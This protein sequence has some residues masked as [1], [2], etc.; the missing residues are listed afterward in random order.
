AAHRDPRLKASILFNGDLFGTARY[1]THP[2]STSSPDQLGAG[3]QTTQTGY[4]LRKMMQEDFSGQLANSG[5]NMPIIRYAEVLL[6]YLEAKLEAGDP[7]NQA[8]LDQ[9]INQVRGRTSV[10]LPPVTVTDPTQLRPILRNE[11]RLELAFEGIRYWDLLRW[12]TAETVLNGDFYGAPYP[13]ATRMRKKD[14][15]DD[16]YHRWYVTTRRFRP[17]TDYRWP[18]PQAERNI[19]P[20]LGQNDGY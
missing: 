17:A 19:N 3:K 12:R 13:T 1:V 11:R 20:N 9:T 4:G 16:A 2:D 18:V 7:I 10:A 15:Q 6:G 8:L 5:T 14:N